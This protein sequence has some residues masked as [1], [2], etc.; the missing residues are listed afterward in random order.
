[1]KSIDGSGFCRNISFEDN[2]FKDNNAL[3]YQ[4]KT[5]GTIIAKAQLNLNMSWSL[6]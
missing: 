2:E 3:N 5:K 6:T 1:M 4:G